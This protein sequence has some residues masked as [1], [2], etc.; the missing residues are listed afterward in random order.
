MERVIINDQEAPADDP[1]VTETTAE[2][3]TQQEEVQQ[4]DR[5][6]W[7]PEKFENPEAFAKSYSDL[8]SKIGQREEDLRTSINQQIQYDFH[9]NRPA[10]VGEYKIPETINEVS[11]RFVAAGVF[12]LS[13]IALVFIQLG[14]YLGF[15]F[16]LILIIN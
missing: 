7:L 11:A 2:E 6:E 5:P 15:L 10:S 9:K 13:L 12:F 8:E 16:N 1:Q 14:S 4:T 3:T